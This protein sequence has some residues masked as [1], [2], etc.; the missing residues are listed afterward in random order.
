M[1]RPLWL[2]L[3]AGNCDGAKAPTAA[4]V[5]IGLTVLGCGVKAWLEE[6]FLCTE[7]GPEVYDAY[8]SQTGMLFPFL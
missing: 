7:L 8:A 4:L 6:W 2:G 5:G 1:R 3:R